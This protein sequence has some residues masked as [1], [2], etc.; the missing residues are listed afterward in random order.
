MPR[1]VL[2]SRQLA[3]VRHRGRFH[4][5]VESATRC[6]SCTRPI[7]RLIWEVTKIGRAIWTDP[8][9]ITDYSEVIPLAWLV[10]L[11]VSWVP[12]PTFPITAFEDYQP[13]GRGPFVCSWSH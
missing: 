5:V 7:I 9:R 12:G 8:G 2:S 1:K 4:M 11:P 3:R 6:G 13:A 10:A